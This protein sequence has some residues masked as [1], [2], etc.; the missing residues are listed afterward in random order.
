MS[1]YYQLQ[2]AT[3][4]QGTMSGLRQSSYLD[5]PF[6]SVDSSNLR[7]STDKNN[8]VKVLAQMFSLRRTAEGSHSGRVSLRLPRLR[9]VAG[10]GG[11]K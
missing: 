7:K 9:Q 3:G 11:T 1:N 10:R 8:T 6:L 5:N 4:L 2:S